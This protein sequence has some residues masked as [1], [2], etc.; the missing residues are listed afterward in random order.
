[1]IIVDSQKFKAAVVEK[2][3]NFNALAELSGLKHT[4]ITR[5]ANSDCKSHVSTISKIAGVLNVSPSA[6]L[7]GE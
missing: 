2:G 5:L 7:K 4:T 6:L 1:M 3:L